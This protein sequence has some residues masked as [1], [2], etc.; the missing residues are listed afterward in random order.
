MKQ[1]LTITDPQEWDC[2]IDRWS[3]HLL[4]GWAWGEL[5]RH[6]GWAPVRVQVGEALAQILF[7]QLPLGLSIA[8]IPKGPVVDWADE[9]TRN[10]LLAALHPIAKK[11][12][13]IFLKIEPNVQHSDPPSP[14]A[15]AAAQGLQQ[16]GFIPAGS[17]QPRRSQVL[18]I[19]GSDEAILGAMKQK[20]RYNI[21]L[22]GR[23][24]IA[25]R[26][27]TAQDVGTFHDLS[28]LTAERDGFGVH[29]LAYYQT[30]YQ[31]FAPDRC[32]LLLAE[33]EG[34]P[35]AGLMVFKQKQ[36]AYYFYGASSN[37]ERNRMPTYLLQWAAIEWARQQRCTR[38]DLWG[39]P[40]AEPAELEAE[41]KNRSDGLWGVYR[42]KRG[43]GGDIVRSLGA[44]D[45]V[46]K[47]ALYNLYKWWR[48]R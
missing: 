5:K 26:Q 33:Y 6:F 16:A 35:L 47:P 30:A 44:F 25:I 28:R 40:D 17:I 4:Q 3:G 21:R 38:Y 10:A 34:T 48:R 9:S 15:G 22:A 12:R 8:Y 24:G 41:F 18:D 14:Q 7:R 27:G 43:F 46:Y 13:A 37:Q 23:K 11:H 19:T 39:I 2:L 36:T 29:S 20:T 32:A 45:F 42:F 1:P 31:L